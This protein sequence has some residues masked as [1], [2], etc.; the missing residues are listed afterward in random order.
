MFVFPG[1]CVRLP[2]ACVRFHGV[3][4]RFLGACERFLG[5]C[6]RFLGACE[7]FPGV[8]VRFLGACERLP[9]VCERFP[10]VCVRFPPG[11]AS[12]TVTMAT[13]ERCIP[14]H[15]ADKHFKVPIACILRA[16]CI[17]SVLITVILSI[18]W[19]RVCVANTRGK[20]RGRT[21]FCV[22]TII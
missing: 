16:D 15:S 5:V 14:S 12:V 10:G 8:R 7:R 13:T 20:C 18:S 2:G 17:L 19:N 21:L 3:C 9:G 6:V 22:L 1:V 4:E 11:V